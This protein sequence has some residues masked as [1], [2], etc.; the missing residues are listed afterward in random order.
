MLLGQSPSTSDALAMGMWLVCFFGVIGGIL[1]IVWLARQL[2]LSFQPAG[3]GQAATK[4]ELDDLHQCVE[5]RL[6]KF[7]VDMREEW[8]SFRAEVKAELVEQRTERREQFKELEHTTREN[9]H[10]M[11]GGMQSL[12]V[13]IA[14]VEAAMGMPRAVSLP[15][16]AEGP[17]LR[18]HPGSGG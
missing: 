17:G 9:F 13:G 8:V 11:A 12:I 7:R 14:R 10:R 6:E 5:K 2:W 16:Q 4:A 1:G 15:P 3:D 18:P